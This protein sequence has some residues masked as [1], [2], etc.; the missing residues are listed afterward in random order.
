MVTTPPVGRVVG[1]ITCCYVEWPRTGDGGTKTRL[2]LAHLEPRGRWCLRPGLWAPTPCS[3]SSV[4][5]TCYLLMAPEAMCIGKKIKPRPFKKVFE[6][7]PWWS[8]G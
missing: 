1:L 4:S 2:P 7:L 8:S 5:L 6:G 3:Q